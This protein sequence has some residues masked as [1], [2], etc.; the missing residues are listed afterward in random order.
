MADAAAGIAPIKKPPVE[1]EDDDDD[2][3]DDD[4]VLDSFAPLIR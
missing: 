1:D 3:D 4:E 2:D